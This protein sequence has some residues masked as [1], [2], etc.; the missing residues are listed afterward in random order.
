MGACPQVIGFG[1]V[2]AELS[3]KQDVLFLKYFLCDKWLVA[4]LK[5][6]VMRTESK[7]GIAV[8]HRM[9]NFLS[10]EYGTQ[11]VQECEFFFARPS[12][13]NVCEQV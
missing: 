10:G 5:I 8:M 4:N 1:V 7:E 11:P 2:P 13:G 3:V 12:F 6:F 9:Q